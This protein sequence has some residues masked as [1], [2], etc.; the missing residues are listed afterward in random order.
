MTHIFQ[1][2]SILVIDVIFILKTSKKENMARESETMVFVK[3][4]AL[5]Y[6]VVVILSFALR[7]PQR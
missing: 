4:S 1:V 7:C 3:T 5:A 2:P 6:R